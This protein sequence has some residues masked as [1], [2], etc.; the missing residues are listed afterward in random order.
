MSL[1]VFLSPFLGVPLPPIPSVPLPGFPKY[2]ASAVSTS[3][4]AIFVALESIS[5]EGQ[6]S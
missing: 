2:D 4:K 6:T 3:R 5:V 1:L